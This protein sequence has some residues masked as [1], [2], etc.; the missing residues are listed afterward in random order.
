MCMSPAYW[1][2][3]GSA[4]YFEATSPWFP[5]KNAPEPGAFCLLRARDTIGTTNGYDC[6][7]QCLSDSEEFPF[8]LRSG[9]V[10]G[11]SGFG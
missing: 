5:D 2:P 9:E 6:G 11:P 4:C 10:T 7:S 8:R 3:F 1:T